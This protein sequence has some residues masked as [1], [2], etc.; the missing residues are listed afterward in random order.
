MWVLEVPQL[1]VPVFTTKVVDGP[2]EDVP[3]FPA[4]ETLVLFKVVLAVLVQV[5]WHD[6]VTG[7]CSTV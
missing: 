5:G 2:L 7:L 3:E 4:T 1:R 6:L